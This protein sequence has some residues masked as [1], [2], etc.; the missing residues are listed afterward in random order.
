MLFSLNKF[1]VIEI[2]LDIYISI[3]IS[4]VWLILMSIFIMRYFQLN[5][6][7]AILFSVRYFSPPMKN[8]IGT[9]SR[10]KS[11]HPLAQSK[12]FPLSNA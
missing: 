5:E 3:K 2:L 11:F 1:T 4:F 8:E 10:Q 6:Q 7:L 12:Q 9:V